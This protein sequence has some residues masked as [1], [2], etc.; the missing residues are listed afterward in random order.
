MQ[1]GKEGINFTYQTISLD[2]D[3]SIMLRIL[4]VFTHISFTNLSELC[5]DNNNVHFRLQS[6]D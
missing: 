1:Q 2:E 6:I 4:D 3:I 5:Y